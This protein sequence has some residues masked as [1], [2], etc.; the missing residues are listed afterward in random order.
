MTLLFEEVDVQYALDVVRDYI[1]GSG[2][3]PMSACN[4][5]EMILS[6]LRRYES[7]MQHFNADPN[8]TELPRAVYTAEQLQSY[9]KGEPCGISSSMAA[10]VFLSSLSTD[11]MTLK[12]LEPELPNGG[13]PLGD[14]EEPP[15][16]NKP[17]GRPNLRLTAGSPSD[18]LPLLQREPKQ[19]Q[20]GGARLPVRFSPELSYPSRQVSDFTG[21]AGNGRKTPR[22]P[23]CRIRGQA[24]PLIGSGIIAFVIAS[25]A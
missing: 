22:L 21:A 23:C 24:A 25:H 4:G 6:I 14:Q 13:N 10:E 1:F 11:L 17:H 9:V 7:K 18:L 2:S 19:C 8:G 5:T 15:E 16:L 20:F 3:S 12:R